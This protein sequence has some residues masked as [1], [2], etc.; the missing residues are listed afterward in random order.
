MKRE[1][2]EGGGWAIAPTLGKFGVT[3]GDEDKSR[4]WM[5]LGGGVRRARENGGVSE[6]ETIA[7]RG[8]LVID[9]HTLRPPLPSDPW[10][11]PTSANSACGACKLKIV[12]HG[13]IVRSSPIQ[14]DMINKLKINKSERD[15]EL[16]VDQNDKNI[17]LED[18]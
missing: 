15:I 16:R 7:H 14:E 10:T 11:L 5:R 12:E 4:L 13:K 2:D 17:L 3:R 18:Q 9:S 1:R 8:G 6:E